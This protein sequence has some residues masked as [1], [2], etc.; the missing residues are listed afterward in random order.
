MKELMRAYN[1]LLMLDPITNDLDITEFG[2]FYCMLLEDW[3]KS[4]GEDI[5]EVLPN[6]VDTIYKLNAEE[7]RY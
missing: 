4:H 6:L 7:G 1:L 2:S 3:C 5:L